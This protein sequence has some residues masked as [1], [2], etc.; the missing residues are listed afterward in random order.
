M[1][2]ATAP[3]PSARRDSAPP[4]GDRYDKLALLQAALHGSHKRHGEM[5]FKSGM[6]GWLE[7]IP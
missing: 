3:H 7:E 1:T 5:D 2:R 4:A 6:K